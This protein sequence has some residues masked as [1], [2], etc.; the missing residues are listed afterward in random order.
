MVMV[1]AS[2]VATK[3]VNCTSSKYEASERLQ[4]GLQSH[5]VVTLLR[6]LPD[7]FFHPILFYYYLK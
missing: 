5:L 6:Y 1:V 7:L 2:G 3:T 4:E